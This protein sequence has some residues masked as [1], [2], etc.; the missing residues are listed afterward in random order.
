LAPGGC[1]LAQARYGKIKVAVREK[2]ATRK[3]GPTR[4]R[5]T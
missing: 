2:E 5:H 3:A 1:S 4:V